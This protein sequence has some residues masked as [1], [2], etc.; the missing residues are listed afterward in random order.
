MGSGG[1]NTSEEPVGKTKGARPLQDVNTPV[2]HSPHGDQGPPKVDHQSKRL[3]SA[4]RQLYCGD[5]THLPTTSLSSSEC[6]SGHLPDRG[7][8]PQSQGGSTGTATLGGE[9]EEG[10]A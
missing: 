9:L 4:K 1:R 8:A 2:T 3:W 7:L 6:S 10:C 5:G